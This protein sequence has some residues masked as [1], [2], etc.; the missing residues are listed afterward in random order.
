[1]AWIHE[2]INYLHLTD[3]VSYYVRQKH[4]W[5]IDQFTYKCCI[6]ALESRFLWHKI[7]TTLISYLPSH[8][9]TMLVSTTEAHERVPYVNSLCKVSQQFWM[10][11]VM[12]SLIFR[13]H[14]TR[15][16]DIINGLSSDTKIGFKQSEPI[17]PGFL[18]LS[19]EKHNVCPKLYKNWQNNTYRFIG[20]NYFWNSTFHLNTI[21]LTMI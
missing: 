17:R 20:D 9:Y 3:C 15:V 13:C 7:Y 6:N 19:Y 11:V 2:E 8:Y 1:M 16:N 12:F 5:D 4:C 14:Y 10:I 18:K 21:R